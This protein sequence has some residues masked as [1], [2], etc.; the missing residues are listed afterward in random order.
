MR[1]AYCHAIIVAGGTGNRFGSLIPKQFLQLRGKP[2]IDWSIATFSQLT[3]INSLI[4]VSHPDWQKKTTEVLAPYRKSFREIK[5]VEGG[6]S[7]Q[8]SVYNGI[9]AVNGNDHDVVLIHDSARPLIS[10]ECIKRVINATILTGAAIPATDISDSI[11]SIDSGIVIEYP[12]RENIKAV[13]TPQGFLLKKIITA[14][15]SAP[16]ENKATDDGSLML[17]TGY[18]VAV[19]KGE[20]SNIKITT[21]EDLLRAEF[22]LNH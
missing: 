6:N 19:V 7:R 2:I 14:H 10:V 21:K 3:E 8:Q 20:T 13:Q 16:P 15:L 4:V 18:P 5:V 11:V 22:F 17:N 12:D 9:S 1:K